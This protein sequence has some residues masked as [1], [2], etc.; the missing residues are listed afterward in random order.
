[1]LAIYGRGENI[2]AAETLAPL[3]SVF[4]SPSLRLTRLAV[5]ASLRSSGFAPWLL[6]VG[7]IVVAAAQEPRMFRSFGVHLT[8]EAAWVAAAALSTVLGTAVRHTRT[9]PYT[10]AVYIVTAIASAA[11]ATAVALVECLRGAGPDAA[12]LLELAAVAF[13]LSGPLALAVAL[14]VTERTLPAWAFAI[15]T[16]MVCATLAVHSA[17][18]VWP[19]PVIAASMACVVSTGAAA[20]SYCLKQI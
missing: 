12:D 5:V 19:G 11:M 1:M 17:A 18:A 20:R 8:R 10:I 13:A 14:A 6:A 4:S 16:A 9:A 15:V 7:W 3:A 2:R